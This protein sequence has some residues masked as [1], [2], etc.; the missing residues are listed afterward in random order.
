MAVA[1]PS[2][3]ALCDGNVAVGLNWSQE[4]N[5]S[6]GMQLESARG[7][8]HDSQLISIFLLPLFSMFNLALLAR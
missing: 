3:S 1:V 5:T 2:S 4:A 8:S 6:P 7:A